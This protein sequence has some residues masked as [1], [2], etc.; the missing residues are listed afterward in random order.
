[1]SVGKKPKRRNP[2]RN[3]NPRRRGGQLP[4]PRRWLRH[5]PLPVGIHCR[6]E[7]ENENDDVEQLLRART[8]QTATTTTETVPEEVRDDDD[9][10]DREG[11][12][13]DVRCRVC[14][15]LLARGEEDGESICGPA[16][17]T[18][19]NG[20]TCT[21]LMAR[22]RCDP[23]RS[24]DQHLSVRERICYTQ[25]SRFSQGVVSRQ[26]QL[27]LLG[28]HNHPC[29]LQVLRSLAVTPLPIGP[30]AAASTLMGGWAF[31][32]KVPSRVILSPWRRRWSL[33]PI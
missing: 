16:I 20:S 17:I 19:A 3:D 22:A 11:R 29:F 2:S 12:T 18:M 13:E 5:I 25:S 27:V 4:H 21:R 33:T 1:M 7:E 32:E 31:R 9:E 30:S 14:P 26:R 28:Y 8:E 24:V 23:I 15:P 10:T 6:V